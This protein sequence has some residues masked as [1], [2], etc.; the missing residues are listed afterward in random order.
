MRIEFQPVEEQMSAQGF[1]IVL[2]VFGAALCCLGLLCSSDS[3]IGDDDSPMSSDL[4]AAESL[5]II[6]VSIVIIAV[7]G[8]IAVF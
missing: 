5:M 3:N 2:L 8:M 6:G 4:D 7:F 1:V